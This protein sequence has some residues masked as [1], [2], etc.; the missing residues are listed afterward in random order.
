MGKPQVSLRHFLLFTGLY[1][2]P[3]CSHFASLKECLSSL[4]DFTKESQEKLLD[5]VTWRG[6]SSRVGFKEYQTQPQPAFLTRVQLLR[7]VPNDVASIE[8]VSIA[9]GRGGC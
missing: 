7:E 1:R 5:F 4:V 8:N 9:V 6:K 2:S 3:G